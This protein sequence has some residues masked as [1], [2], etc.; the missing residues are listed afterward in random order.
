MSD[1][2][3][4]HIADYF[5]AADTALVRGGL[6]SD[7]RGRAERMWILAVQ[8][9]SMIPAR[10]ERGKRAKAGMLLSFVRVNRMVDFHQPAFKKLALSLSS[11]VLE[12]P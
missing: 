1:Q 2:L 4:S 10:S 9:A 6:T 5:A 3:L 8:A 12:R 11:D 7:E